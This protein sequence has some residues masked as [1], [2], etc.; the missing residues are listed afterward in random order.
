MSNN[1]KE[2]LSNN[3]VNYVR[4]DNEIAQYKEEINSIK[5]KMNA[6]IERR[7]KYEAGLIRIIEAN[8]LEKKDIVISDGKIKYMQ[9]KTA[10]PVTKKHI[11]KCLKDFFKNKEDAE[12]LLENIYGNR[13]VNVKTSIK[14]YNK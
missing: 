3:V 1:L 6:I 4:C 5:E 13:E 11:E 10:A 14:R 9:S 7:D 12:K 2:D 8:N